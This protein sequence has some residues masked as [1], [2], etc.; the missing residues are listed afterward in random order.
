MYIMGALS[1]GLILIPIIPGVRSLPMRIPIHRG[2][3]SQ[4]YKSEGIKR[5]KK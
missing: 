3:W 1:L 2:I 4:Y 5:R